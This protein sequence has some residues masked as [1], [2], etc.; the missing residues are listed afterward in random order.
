GRR[1][2]TV[3]LM[4]ADAASS[5]R[6]E[7]EMDHAAADGAG[8]CCAAGRAELPDQV[9]PAGD[10]GTVPATV[11]TSRPWAAP[12]AEVRARAER[13][14]PVAAG[15]F[16]MGTEDADRNPA[17]GESPIRSVDVAAFRIDPA[18]V[19]NAEFAAFVEATGYVTEAEEFGWSYVF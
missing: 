14:V 15:P 13:A 8:R 7:A 5:P 16:R 1:R 19:T 11:T 3:V 9:G 17:D 18:C 2:P 12:A 4:S 10:G 6:A